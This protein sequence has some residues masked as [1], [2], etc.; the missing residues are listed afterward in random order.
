VAPAVGSVASFVHV[1][2]LARPPGGLFVNRRANA[3]FPLLATIAVSAGT[4]PDDGL[5]RPSSTASP[6]CRDTGRVKEP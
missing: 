2:L 5:R 6:A 3:L 4:E 1:E